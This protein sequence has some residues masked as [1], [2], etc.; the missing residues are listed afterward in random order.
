MT[1]DTV[2]PVRSASS[3]LSF[4]RAAMLAAVLS[5]HVLRTDR[6]SVLNAARASSL[7]EV[8]KSTY[9]T[10]ADLHRQYIWSRQ[11]RR[12]LHLLYAFLRGKAYST[13]EPKCDPNTKP[14]GSFI[15]GKFYY[16][17]VWMASNDNAHTWGDDAMVA[18]INDW[19]DG[20]ASPFAK[21]HVAPLEAQHMACA[22]E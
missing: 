21:A 18:A 9:A 5:A 14:N 4:V 20:A 7:A 17:S 16:R 22:A 2:S 1:I 11:D 8:R 13:V 15:L 10:H 3:A 6:N 19:L 12:A